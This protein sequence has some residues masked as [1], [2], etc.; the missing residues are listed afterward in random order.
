MRLRETNRGNLGTDVNHPQKKTLEYLQS[1]VTNT[2]TEIQTPRRH[3]QLRISAEVGTILENLPL[4]NESWEQKMNNT[5]D[6][7]IGT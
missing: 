3:L 7:H 2:S 6:C 5:D 4:V 1:T